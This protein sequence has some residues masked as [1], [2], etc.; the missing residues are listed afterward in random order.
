MRIEV[1]NGCFSYPKTSTRVLKDISFKLEDANIMTILGKNGIGKTT[2]LKCMS[3][4]FKWD[5]GTTFI[6]DKEFN[7]IRDIKTV[8][9]VPQAHAQTLTYPYS[10]ID[11]VTMG[12]VRYMGALSIPSKQ[13]VEF[14]WQALKT[15]GMQDYA[16]R[17]C[18]QLSGGQ[19]QMVFIARAL[20]AQ[21]EMLIMDE[22]ES[23]LDIKNQYRVIELVEELKKEKGI[24][25]IINTHYPEHALRISDKVLMLGHDDYIFGGKEI[26]TPEN[27]RKYFDVNA[28][29][30]FI[31]ENQ[32]KYESF[33]IFG[34]TDNE[35]I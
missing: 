4:M 5:S 6:N 11:M 30:R 27:M 16:Q 33:V 12:R 18:T 26:I 17:A 3:G 14:A 22:P 21:P 13:D 31:E 8:A 28:D 15:V 24:S 29:V 32:K 20:T 19:L 1:K 10:V 7:S 2:L 25:S 34:T 23:H 35:I 9:F